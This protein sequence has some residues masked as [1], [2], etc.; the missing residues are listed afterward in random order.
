MKY[1]LCPFVRDTFPG[2]II[3]GQTKK[4]DLCDGLGRV[5]IVVVED[6]EHIPGIQ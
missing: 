1:L 3:A 5:R 6:S 2:E 4:E